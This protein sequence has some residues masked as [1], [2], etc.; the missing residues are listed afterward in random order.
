MF[1]QCREMR[2]F[3]ARFDQVT[4]FRIAMI[5]KLLS[6]QNRNSTIVYAHTPNC[7]F[8]LSYQPQV[9]WY[10]DHYYALTS[11]C[12]P[13]SFLLSWQN[14][15]SE[16]L[17]HHLKLSNT[18]Q[19]SYRNALIY[20]LNLNISRRWAPRIWVKN[21]ALWIY[22]NWNWPFLLP[23]KVLSQGFWIL[24]WLAEIPWEGENSLES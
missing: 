14:T 23:R 8:L 3:L 9:L 1:L 10:S 13:T 5:S 21:W 16:V 6:K 20:N 19:A 22:P 4:A 11:T 12:L 17:T 24:S 18:S 15:A 7:S 2:T